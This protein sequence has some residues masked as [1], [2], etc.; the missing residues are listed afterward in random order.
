[1]IGIL[2]HSM[3]GLGP[4]WLATASMLFLMLM[5]NIDKDSFKSKIDWPFLFFLAGIISFVR[6][7]NQLGLN[8]LVGTHVEFLGRLMNYDIFVFIIVLAL[9]VFLIRLLLPNNVTIIILCAVLIPL[10]QQYGINPWMVCFS[11]LI[12]S[13]AWFFPYQCTFYMTFHNMTGGQ[14]FEHKDVTVF[15]IIN[16]LISILS[17]LLSIPIWRLMGIL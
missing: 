15:I 8:E 11:V 2:T 16:S 6:I 7:F 14:M 5:G 13:N 1:M 12:F 3:H 9:V 10:A 17:L 4:S